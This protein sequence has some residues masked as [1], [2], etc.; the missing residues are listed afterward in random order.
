MK[1]RKN[2]VGKDKKVA[3]TKNGRVM[4]LSKCA[5]WDS[6][7]FIKEQKTSGSLC[8]LGMKAPLSKISLIGPLFFRG[9]N[10]L[11]KK[12][13]MNETVNKLLLAGDQFMLEM[14][15]REPRFTYSTCIPFIQNIKSVH[16]IEKYE[17]QD[18]FIKT[19]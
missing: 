16:N 2:T 6:K 1:C 17:I 10:K 3:K 14:H 13:K 19:N 7:K 18:V 11:I 4:L 5:V 12:D 15:L 9:I 8:S